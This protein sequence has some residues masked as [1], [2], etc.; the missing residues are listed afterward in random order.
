M[1]HRVKS[2]ALNG[3]TYFTSNN[4]ILK[5]ESAGAVL[6]L[7]GMPRCLDLTLALTGAPG[8]LLT[9]T[10]S[11]PTAGANQG[12]AYRAVWCKR[13][14]NNNLI[15]GVPS[16]RFY[17]TNTA[18]ATRD[19]NV[20]TRLPPEITTTHFL[21]LYASEIVDFSDTVVPGDDLAQIFEY[22]PTTTD[23]A[24]GTLTITDNV[25]DAFRGPAL[26]TNANEEGQAQQN[27][28]PP[29]GRDICV[30]RGRLLVANYTEPHR[31]ELQLLGTTGMANAQTI[32][33]AG[34]IYTLAATTTVANG[35]FDWFNGGTQALNVEQTAKELVYV[36]NGY[37]ANTGVYAYYTSGVDDA[38]GRILIEERGVGGDPFYVT[39]STSALGNLFSPAL[40]TS[41]TTYGSVAQRRPNR[42]RVGKTNEEAFPDGDEIIVGGED[43]EIQRIIPLRSSVIVIKDES[44]WR[45]VEGVPGEEPTFLDDEVAIA[46]R[47]SA[48]K[49]NNVVFFLSN[50]G[51]VAVSDNGAQIAGRP[52]ERFVIAGLERIDAP[53]HDIIVGAGSKRARLYICTVWDPARAERTCYMFSPIAN[54]GKGAWTKRRLNANAFA[55]LNNRLLYAL[56]SET[57]NVLRQRASERDG[58]PWYRDFCEEASTF[59]ITSI[60]TTEKIVTGTFASGVDYED[61]EGGPDIGWK[62]YDGDNQYLVTGA[63]GASD[64]TWTLVV[65]TTDGLTTGA[66]TIYRP[67]RWTV[68]WAPIT[69][70]NPLDMKQFTDVIMKA[71]THD[72]YAVDFEYAN[73]LDTKETPY[74]DIWDDVPPADRVFVPKASGERA[75][76]GNNDFGAT[77]GRLVPFNEIR[78]QVHPKRA[79]G[80][81]L[82]VRVSGGTAEGYIGIKAVIAQTDSKESNKGRA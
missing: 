25:P 44:V 64:P 33:I 9:D 31:L 23:I 32:T 35:E 54:K 34:V 15:V 81:H 58:D 18:G 65:N 39:C 70:G 72:A 53:N 24:N 11:S 73:Q 42:I 50:Q 75:S 20:T 12:R 37:A 14:A 13:D 56:N 82:S 26:Y 4:G 51:F 45:L 40:P 79:M 7:A 21:A 28:R 63:N 60:N 55:V 46:G 27:Q 76:I 36:I 62:L 66:K 5:S 22:F 2:A 68:E 48:A 52:V 80:S 8:T 47:D 3:N 69:G 16:S 67:V 19:V 57:G 59:T 78:T 74:H 10:G 61:Y 17:I 1:S 41:G 77:P 38:P 29:L 49:L 43:E 71:E 30:Y 6:T